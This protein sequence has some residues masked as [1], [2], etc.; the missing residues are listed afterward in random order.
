MRRR[1]PEAFP[2]SYLG[3]NR[4]GPSGSP[5]RTF[6]NQHTKIGFPSGACTLRGL[7]TKPE[8]SI[9]RFRGA[10]RMLRL[11]V[12][13]EITVFK[14]PPPTLDSPVTSLN[15]AVMMESCGQA[16]QKDREVREVRRADRR[17]EPRRFL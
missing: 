16:C 6:Q 2:L 7:D 9:I 4:V 12:M 13:Y 10:A 1:N 17:P 15:T 14:Y 8:Q 11:A 5:Q 3:C